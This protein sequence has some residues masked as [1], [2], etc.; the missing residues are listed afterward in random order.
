MPDDVA[1][2]KISALRALGATVEQV[3]PASIVDKKQYVITLR[4]RRIIKQNPEDSSLTSLRQVPC[5]VKKILNE[6]HRIQNR[7]NFDAHFE[8]TGP[9]IW[10][11]TN[12]RID[13]FVSGAGDTSFSPRTTSTSNHFSGTGGTLAGIGQYIKSLNKNV[14]VALADP[15]GSGLYNKVR[16]FASGASTSDCREGETW[17][18]V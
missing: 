14:V 4:R 9:E 18:N 15:E 3:R 1:K 7:S 17:R 12:G 16:T 8:G 5:L 2:E 10:R 13:A 11:Q 6:A